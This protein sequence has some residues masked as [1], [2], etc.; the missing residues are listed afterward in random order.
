MPEPGLLPERIFGLSAVDGR[1]TVRPGEVIAFRF[2]AKNGTE[3]PT[4]PAL[5]VL[6]LPAGW[7]PLDPL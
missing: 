1:R 2:R 6:V 5:L 3:V 7:S 4:P